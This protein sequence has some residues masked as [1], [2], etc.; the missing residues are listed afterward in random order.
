MSECKILLSGANGRLG[1]AIIASAGEAGCR[2]IAGVD[3]APTAG[4]IP[5]YGSLSELPELDGAYRLG[6]KRDFIMEACEYQDSFL[7]FTPNIAVVLN[8]D[9]DHTDY[10]SGIE[11]IVG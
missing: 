4:T 6:S 8:I 11:Q 10:F 1:R 2:I 7:S 5:M 3:I 9:L